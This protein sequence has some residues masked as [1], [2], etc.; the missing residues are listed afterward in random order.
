LDH[1]NAAFSSSI[2]IRMWERE[3]RLVAPPQEENGCG[4]ASEMARQFFD[5]A[6]GDG[7]QECSSEWMDGIGTL[8]D[9]FGCWEEDAKGLGLIGLVWAG[10]E[11]VSLRP[12]HVVMVLMARRIHCFGISKA[13][14]T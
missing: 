14:S 9:A 6:G 13:G 7:C 1:S 3:R 11:G 10:S 12:R 4:E 8:D 5:V 2:D